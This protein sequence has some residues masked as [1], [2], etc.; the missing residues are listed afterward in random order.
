MSALKSFLRYLVKLEKIDSNLIE[1]FISPKSEGKLPSFLYQSEMFELLSFSGSECNSPLNLRDFAI[2][3][4]LYSTGVRV[5]E[6]VN[7][8]FDRLNIKDGVIKIDGKGNK[9][10]LVFLGFN[11]K[12]ALQNYL[13]VRD[14]LSNKNMFKSSEDKSS[15][16]LT[17]TGTKLS[18]SAV[19]LIVDAIGK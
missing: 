3:M 4:V 12:K 9:E 11:A 14:E 6:L 7:M 13:N 16:F 1:Y 10:R 19:L 5:S 18:R 2:L 8:T 15:L 17:R